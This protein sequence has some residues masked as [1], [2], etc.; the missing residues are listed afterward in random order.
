MSYFLTI[1][2]R[3][4]VIGVVIF[5]LLM[6]FNIFLISMINQLAE[7]PLKIIDHPLEVSNAASYANVEVMRM[8]K[9]LEQVILVEK[10]YE[11]NIL[12]DKIRISEGKVYVALDIIAYDILGETGQQLQRDA[13]QLFEEWKPIRREII[14]AIKNGRSDRALNIIRND[15]AEH[16]EIME[17]KLVELNQYARRKAIEF[18]NDV[19]SLEQQLRR[20]SIIGMIL[21]LICILVSIIWISFNVLTSIRSLSVQLNDIIKS[22]E[23]KPVSL[24]GNDELV[25]LS[26][27]FNELVISLD[28]ELWLKEGN[29]KLYSILNSQKNIDELLIN[30]VE[31]LRA[32]CN[33]LSV[34]YYQL[35]E[36]KIILK[37]SSNRLDF[38]KDTYEM[39]NGIVGECVYRNRELTFTYEEM[40]MEEDVEFPMKRVLASPVGIGNE[41]FGSIIL[42][43]SGKEKES[44]K[45]LIKIAMKDFSQFIESY[46]QSNQIDLL[47]KDSIK[48]N[49]EL[50]IRQKELEESN[51]YRTQ[52]FAN[53][54]HE[55][56]TPLNSIIILSKLLLSKISKDD[57]E[58]TKIS[59]INK[60]A[61][62]LLEIINDILDLSKIESGKVDLNEEIFSSKE[63]LSQLEGMYTPIINDKGLKS[64]FL[65]DD[66]YAFFGD[67]DKL[68]HI[69]SNLI[70]NAVK[71]TNSGQITLSLTCDLQSTLPIC[72]EVTDTG[73]GI[74][75]DKLGV[76]FDEFVQSDGSIS[77]NFGGTGLGLAICKNYTSILGGEMEVSSK[78]DQGSTFR[79]FL[80]KTFI[81]E[82]TTI[83]LEKLDDE[84]ELNNRKIKIKPSL[85]E[86]QIMICDDE[87]YNVFALAAALE[88][89]GIVPL[90]ALNINSALTLAKSK[91]VDMIFM[92]LMMPEI[93]GFEAIELLRS[94][95]DLRDI[96]IVMITAAELST[97][98]IEQI[99]KLNYILAK[100]PIKPSKLIEIINTH[101]HG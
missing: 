68:Y 51:L 86:K 52:F 70:S 71:F 16:A 40:K 65:S 33:L 3:F 12:I 76:I 28:E 57:E 11:V 27:V 79:L 56:K 23:L 30:Y 13:R 44:F 59:V 91:D 38:M 50:L 43:V 58:N 82:K 4:I 101:L 22:G 60:A 54:S 24:E 37:S 49:E 69:L 100:K 75:N 14:D 18:Q 31:S 42:V 35:E 21:V 48:T 19:I 89:E 6:A 90:T 81:A 41:V 5:I 39:D 26:S 72:F 74:D 85:K 88:E 80:P 87:P 8:Q 46:R 61:N 77:R 47:L 9:D 94:K 96:P 34:A 29:S 83:Q 53:V 84:R 15:G 64:Y 93:N 2:D 17:R 97:N 78:V 7:L 55:L 66:D 67:K 62:E 45:E 1:R 92:D 20:I 63:I 10:D 95:S 98:D 36:N 32:Y 99:E 25:G 73:I